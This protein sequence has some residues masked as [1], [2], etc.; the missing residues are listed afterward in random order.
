MP[1]KIVYFLFF[2]MLLVSACGDD[3]SS[4]AWDDDS[5][6]SSASDGADISSGTDDPDESG[7]STKSGSSSS[8]TG[9]CSSTVSSGSN[10]GSRWKDSLSTTD[11]L[12]YIDKI[13]FDDTDTSHT[14]YA[15]F[16]S[17][18]RP[19][20]K[21]YTEF[22]YGFSGGTGYTTGYNVLSERINLVDSLNEDGWYKLRYKLKD[23]DR[24]RS[25]E[26]RSPS[27]ISFTMYFSSVQV[28]NINYIVVPLNREMER[29]VC[30]KVDTLI[31][32][33]D[34]GVITRYNIVDFFDSAHMARVD[35]FPTMDSLR[36]RGCYCS[37]YNLCRGTTHYITAMKD[38]VYCSAGACY[39]RDEEHGSIEGMPFE[40]SFTD[41]RDGKVY[42]TVKIGMQE[43]FAKNLEYAD[44]VST[45]N[46]AG[47]TWCYNND[48][49]YCEK[50]GRL[51]D[52]SGALNLPE[53]YND[54]TLQ[55]FEWF[56]G[57]C[58]AGWHVATSNEFSNI[59]DYMRA[60]TSYDWV[61]TVRDGAVWDSLAGSEYNNITGFSALPGGYRTELGEY[62]GVA[63]SARF[64]V[65][66]RH[67]ATVDNGS[68]SSNNTFML[69]NTKTN[70]FLE[71]GS[72]KRAASYV[73]CVRG[74]GIPD[75]RS[76]VYIA[77]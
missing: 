62:K 45:P 59:W 16:R 30:S 19:N 58:P 31:T 47:H 25:S 7:S 66:W 10:S 6:T 71:S 67:T 53:A 32:V 33:L 4:M 73:R 60:R 75:A 49:M 65:T 20:D 8:K 35:T 77:K 61:Y 46:L 21:I 42:P 3:D 57:I 36:K 44:S 70:G 51:Y 22:R 14:I 54:S 11:T 41:T 29:N 50:F 26:I 27:Y 56:Q 63:V 69:K 43:W 76:Y 74:E 38:Y 28:D 72:K 18:V 40:G 39:Q 2:L 34:S 13:C 15:V 52:W 17:D 55:P 48:E 9:S 1:N 64:I 37:D 24:Y 12:L 5:V 23:M 68:P